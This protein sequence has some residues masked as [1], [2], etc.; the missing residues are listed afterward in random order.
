MFPPFN[1]CYWSDLMPVCGVDALDRRSAMCSDWIIDGI[2][3]ILGSQG[4]KFLRSLKYSYYPTS[5]TSKS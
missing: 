1:I 3:V 2:E 4:V 5:L